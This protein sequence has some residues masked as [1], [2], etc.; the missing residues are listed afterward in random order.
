MG[1]VAQVNSLGQDISLLVVL[2]IS[3]FFF[4]VILV[5]LLLLAFKF[6]KNR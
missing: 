4:G 5:K 1:M 6:F 2:G 3:L